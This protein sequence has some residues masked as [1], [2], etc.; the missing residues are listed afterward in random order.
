MQSGSDTIE[1]DLQEMMQEAREAEE[2]IKAGVTVLTA[3]PALPAKR[4]FTA[5]SAGQEP[6]ECRHWRAT[7]STNPPLFYTI[8]PFLDQV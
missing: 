2:L 6:F 4:L 3:V 7:F 5:G 8:V 1:Q